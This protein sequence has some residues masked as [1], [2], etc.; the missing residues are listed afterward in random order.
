[1]N[2]WEVWSRKTISNTISFD[3]LCGCH[4]EL[5]VWN[6]IGH[7]INYK[8][9]STPHPFLKNLVPTTSVYILPRIK[10]DQN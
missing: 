7:F 6:L 2:G 3:Q 4:F 8:H 5:E 10:L 1:M 9:Q